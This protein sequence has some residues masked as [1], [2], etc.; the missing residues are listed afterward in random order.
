MKIDLGAIE[1]AF[2]L[3][4]FLVGQGTSTVRAVVEIVKARGYKGD[5]DKLLAAAEEADALQ[6]EAAARK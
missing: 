1:Q 3:A 4:V 2:N 6:A 5:T